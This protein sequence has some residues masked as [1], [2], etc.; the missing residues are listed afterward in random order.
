MR[1]G[2]MSATNV[3]ERITKLA[4]PTPTSVCRSS[5]S[6]KF[7]VTAVS[8]VAPLQIS[9]PTMITAL[10]EYFTDSGPM[11]GAAIM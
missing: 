3:G 5:S 6:S 1:S 8:S 2:N 11:K 7:L 4:S 10:R 9:A